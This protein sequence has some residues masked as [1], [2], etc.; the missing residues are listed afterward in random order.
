MPPGAC[1]CHAHVFSDLSRLVPGRVYTPP[2][3]SLE[4][5][6]QMLDVIG[7][8][9]AVIVQPSVYGSDNRA[10][11]DAVARA[12][13]A[14]RA[15]V[16]LDDT[17]TRRDLEMMHDQGARGTRVN[18]LFSGDAERED[19][20]RL[21]RL[22]A[23]QGWHM[24]MLIDVSRFADL[25]GFVRAL[26]VPVV[27]DHMGHMPCA[28]GPNAPGFQALLRLLGE[29]RVWTKLSGSYRITAEA[30]PPYGDVTPFA[31]AL[32]AANPD[33]CVWASDW[34]HPHIP[35][36]MPNDGD[37]VDMLADWVPDT[38]TR[39]RILVDNP[40]RLYGFGS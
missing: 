26:P 40:A 32:V 11:L 9:R 2:A 10:T 27:L 18:A 7:I 22:L 25:E 37:L 13:E 12:G 6:R 29:G 8:K 16:V 21:G 28:E 1:D 14:F 20:F 19:L 23:D 17:A 39:N 24:Q 38:A 5:Y 33:Q 4:A 15:V 30:E 3:A 36:A 34:P 35:V 31:R